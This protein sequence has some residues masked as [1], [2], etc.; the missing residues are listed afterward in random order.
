[1]WNMCKLIEEKNTLVRY[2]RFKQD[3]SATRSNWRLIANQNYT[4]K[5]AEWETAYNQQ[6]THQHQLHSN[7]FLKFY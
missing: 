3:I 1:M 5:E 4:A 7:I 2:I 6:V